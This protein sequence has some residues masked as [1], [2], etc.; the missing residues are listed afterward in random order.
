[1]GAALGPLGPRPAQ[2][3]V[4]RLDCPLAGRYGQSVALLAG[5]VALITGGTGALGRVVSSAF[6]AAGAR[7]VVTH[8][9]EKELAAFRDAVSEGSYELAHVDLADP[10]AVA[11]VVTRTL[12]KHGHLDVLL[13]LAG[14]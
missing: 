10:A 1:M 4:G 5:R 14:G 12:E 13:N 7:A 9:I 8:V 11:A 6:V 2:S 3:G